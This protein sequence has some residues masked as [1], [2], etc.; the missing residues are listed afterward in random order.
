MLK[1]IKSHYFNYIFIALFFNISHYWVIFLV[2]F[3]FLK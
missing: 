2:C 1:R 3:Y